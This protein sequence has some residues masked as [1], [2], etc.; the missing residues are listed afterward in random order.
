[1]TEHSSM[2]VAHAPRHAHVSAACMRAQQHCCS[3][4]FNTQ[5]LRNTVAC[6]NI[7]CN[8][9]H[10][11]VRTDSGCKATCMRACNP[12]G[13]HSGAHKQGVT[14]DSAVLPCTGKHLPCVHVLLYAWPG[15]ANAT[16]PVTAAARHWATH[17][18]ASNTPFALPHST[19]TC[20]ELHV[21]AVA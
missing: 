5:H 19:A 15:H 10:A 1:M 13:C 8:Q 20:W 11:S 18:L 16:L 2:S 21:P 7:A 4:P 17:L 6:K 9:L 14:P 12:C 3:M